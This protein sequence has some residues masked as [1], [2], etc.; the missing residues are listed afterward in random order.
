MNQTRDKAVVAE[1]NS[2][3]ASTNPI[4]ETTVPLIAS[5]QS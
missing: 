4:Q 5:I 3:F 2:L 1:V